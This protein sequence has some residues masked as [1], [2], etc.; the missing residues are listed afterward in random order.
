MI[1]SNDDLRAAL[2]GDLA[3]AFDKSTGSFSRRLGIALARP[4]GTR[5]GEDGVHIVRAGEFRKAV[6]WKLELSSTECE[7]VSLA[8]LY[9]PSAGNIREEKIQ[10]GAETNST[11]SQTHTECK[12]PGAWEGRC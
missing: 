7:F 5:Y 12:D 11:N 1:T 9:S 8:S 3:E 2:P 6:R 10:E 4:A